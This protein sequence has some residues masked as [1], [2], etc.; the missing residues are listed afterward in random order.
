MATSDGYGYRSG[1]GQRVI[2]PVP[3][4]A[5]TA[6]ITIHDAI[7][8]TGYTAGYFGTCTGNGD[9][10][11]GF[12]TGS[13]L[14]PAADGDSNVMVDFSSSS[15]YEFPLESGTVTNALIGKTCDIAA[16][17]RALDVTTPADN[18]LMIT[19]INTDRNTCYVRLR[20]IVNAP[21]A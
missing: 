6:D 19:D 5:S 1:A 10:V 13:V 15:L 14:S 7:T 18:S 9:R 20:D 12:A 16:S 8:S 17:G 4:D 21:A 11:I 2:R 3:V